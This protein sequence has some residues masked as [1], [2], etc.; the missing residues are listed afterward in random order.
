MLSALPYYSPEDSAGKQARLRRWSGAESMS[1][2][3][4]GGGQTLRR[5]IRGC[6][7]S[8]TTVSPVGC[9]QPH[10]HGV[11]YEPAAGHGGPGLQLEGA[12][13]AGHSVRERLHV[14]CLGQ[15]GAG[16]ALCL[17]GRHRPGRAGRGTGTELP[18]RLAYDLGW[19]FPDMKGF[20][21]G[22]RACF[23]TSRLR[24]AQ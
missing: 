17:Q 3:G 15:A 6:T 4:G 2:A 10:K 21:T 13:L 20:S 14:A 22:A 1:G 8:R 12:V 5:A 9:Y 7:A 11:H 19:A 18:R 24:P 16:N 23:F